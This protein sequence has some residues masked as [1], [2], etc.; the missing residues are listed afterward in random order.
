M[1]M[2]NEL[3]LNRSGGAVPMGKLLR[4]LLGGIPR[5]NFVSPGDLL[6]QISIMLRENYQMFIRHR[7]G[8]I[9]KR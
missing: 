3:T 4:M 2:G 8:A 1:V 5:S 7:T 6:L 9:W